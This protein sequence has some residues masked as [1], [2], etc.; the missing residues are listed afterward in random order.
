VAWMSKLIVPFLHNR[1]GIHVK[2]ALHGVPLVQAILI[3][4]HP[5]PI[6]VAA[7]STYGCAF[8]SQVSF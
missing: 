1:F 5:C 2:Y 6:C 3:A 7:G 8:N 4:S